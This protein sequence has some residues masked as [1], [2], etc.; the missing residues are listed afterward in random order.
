MIKICQGMCK[1]TVYKG[2]TQVSGLL[3]QCIGKH[4]NDIKDK[5]Q[6]VWNDIIW[7]LILEHPAAGICCRI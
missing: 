5:G 2:S 1:R 3:F 7:E 6:N 4:K